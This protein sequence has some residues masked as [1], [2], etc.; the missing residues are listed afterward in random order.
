MASVVRPHSKISQTPSELTIKDMHSLSLKC[1]VQFY[2]TNNL[3]NNGALCIC[4]LSLLNAVSQVP[5]LSYCTLV[6]DSYLLYATVFAWKNDEIFIKHP[7]KMIVDGFPPFTRRVQCI[8]K[9]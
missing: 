3:T 9:Y 2:L 7:F 5:S 1:R 6:L 4:L 8:S